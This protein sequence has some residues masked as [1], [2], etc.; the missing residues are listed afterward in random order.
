MQAVIRT[1]AVAT[2][3]SVMNFTTRL[4]QIAAI[5]RLEA[6]KSILNR[7]A[8]PVYLL[9]LLPIGLALL[10]AIAPPM[11]KLEI[12]TLRLVY[13]NLFESAIL[14]L[15][16]FFACARLFMNL[17]QGEMADQS[18]HYYL[19]T[20]VRRETL[21]IG[22]Y[23]FGVVTAMVLL[24]ATTFFSFAITFL[25]FTARLSP[26]IDSKHLVSYLI[27]VA[28]ACI[29]YGAIFLFLGALFRNPIVPAVFLYGWELIN[30]LLPPFLKHVSVIHYLRSL[31]PIQIS[32]GPFAIVAEPVPAPVAITGVLLLSAAFVFLT[33]WMARRMEVKYAGE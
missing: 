11:R 14:R 24:C 30:F 15:A 17:F 12:G 19:L 31:S 27:T 2:E 29:G 3:S 1:E 6:R 4:R 16:V 8:L 7:R 20:P 13:A 26:G 25:P 5:V 33:A 18:L 23:C 28:V 21:A 10:I 9:A 22:K 32:Q